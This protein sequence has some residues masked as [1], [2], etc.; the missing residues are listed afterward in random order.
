MTVRTA[1]MGRAGHEGD[2]WPR[3]SVRAW[4]D[5]LAW[6][7]AG[8]RR[9]SRCAGAVHISEDTRRCL[10]ILTDWFGRCPA[11]PIRLPRRQSDVILRH[12]DDKGERALVS[13]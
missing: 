10:P 12:I 5:C 7:S 11:A 8:R 2:R 3:S 1:A 13:R 6:S 4:R 9:Q